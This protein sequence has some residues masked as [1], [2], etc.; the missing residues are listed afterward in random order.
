[1][2]ITYGGG[3][4]GVPTIEDFGLQGVTGATG[5]QGATGASGTNGAT[6]PS[7]AT[8]ATGA[9]GSAG[10]SGAKGAT[11][12]TGANGATGSTGATGATGPEG[13]VGSAA[14]NAIATFADFGGLPSGDCL[15]Y[16]GIALAGGSFCPAATSGFP[17][18][19][20]P[21]SRWYN[22]ASWI[23]WFRY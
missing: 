18:S 19:D 16:T 11:G 12:A 9:N 17:N 10:A 1:V 23:V 8:G 4:G 3:S 22:K 7:G 21:G 13:K 6:G 2:D 5:P 14:C 15:N 20:G